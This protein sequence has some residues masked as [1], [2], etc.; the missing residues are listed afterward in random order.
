MKVVYYKCSLCEQDWEEDNVFG[1]IVEDTKVTLTDPD[2]SEKHICQACI[3]AIRDF[4]K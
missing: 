3:V 1:V 4:G 2:K